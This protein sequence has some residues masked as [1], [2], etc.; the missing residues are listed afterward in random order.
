MFKKI[1]ER[2]IKK[3]NLKVVNEKEY[4]NVQK[5]RETRRQLK[6]VIDDY[7]DLVEQFA[8]AAN[9][10]ELKDYLATHAN[11]TVNGTKKEDIQKAAVDILKKEFKKN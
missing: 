10:R 6:E 7:N 9:V 8:Q 2:Y 4:E 3:N 1:A 11:A 5:F